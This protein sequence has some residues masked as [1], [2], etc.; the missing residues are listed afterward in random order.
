M[1][2]CLSSCP[3]TH[4]QVDPAIVEGMKRSIEALPLETNAV[5]SV[6]SRLGSL[7]APA[8]AQLLKELARDNHAF[9]HDCLLPGPSQ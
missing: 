7:D 3:R 6:A 9:R 1:H 4:L 8:F 5:S 2:R